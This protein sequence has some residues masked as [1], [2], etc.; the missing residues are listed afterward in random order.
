MSRFAKL[1]GFISALFF[2]CATAFAGQV[3]LLG[4]VIQEDHPQGKSYY[5]FA[6]KV[7][8]YSDGELEVQVFLN[9]ALGN[10]RDMVEGLDLG[11]LHITKTMVAYLSAYM[12]EFQVLDLPYMFRDRKH[13]YKALDSEEV[14]QYFMKELFPKNGFHGLALFDSGIRSIYN[15]RGPI[16]KLEDVKGWKLRVPE[17][18]VFMDIMT[19]LGAAGTPI[20]AGDIY[21]AIQTGVVDGAENSPVFYKTTT[22][23]E[24]APYFS[25]TTH[26]MTPDVV[27][28]N[29]DFFESLSKK[30]Q[31]AI[32]RAAKEME[33]WERNAWVEYENACIAE[34]TAAGVK[35]N[36]DVDR[37]AFRA[38]VK[39]VWDK[40]APIVSQAMID[41]IQALAD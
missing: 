30:N 5:F 18:G 22:H 38:A 26:L 34:L 13:F 29:K 9:S 12:P 35:F 8:E 36:D 3:L 17:G 33:A 6:D 40:Y 41:K 19:S 39:P 20:P 37:D 32:M 14:G 28:M 11:T 31:D 15:R 21:T 4:D 7:K 2:V 24:V 27:V 16:R 1:T 10:H 25:F 23:Y